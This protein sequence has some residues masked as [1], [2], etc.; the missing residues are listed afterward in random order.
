MNLQRFLSY[1]A[2]MQAGEPRQMSIRFA[3]GDREF[4]TVQTVDFDVAAN[5]WTVR[6]AKASG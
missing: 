3:I 5:A 6:L 2:R 1:F 4:L